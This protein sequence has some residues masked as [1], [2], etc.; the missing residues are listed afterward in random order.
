MFHCKL[1]HLY[2][3]GLATCEVGSLLRPQTIYQCCGSHCKDQCV[4][5]NPV[6]ICRLGNVVFVKHFC[7][8]SEL[9]SPCY[10]P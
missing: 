3:A 9:P 1:K 5:G 10:V 2:H 7:V 6:F 8:V 4:E